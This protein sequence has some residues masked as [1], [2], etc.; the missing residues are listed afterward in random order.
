MEREL[1]ERMK[2]VL[3]EELDVRP[4]TLTLKSLL[5]EDLGADS[6]DLV[7]LALQVEERF[8]IEVNERD[9]IQLKTVGDV[10]DY[11]HARVQ[12]S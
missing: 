6:L 4:E 7:N 11:L 3:C 10:F 12:A 1:F 5:V 2:A 9:L 8:E